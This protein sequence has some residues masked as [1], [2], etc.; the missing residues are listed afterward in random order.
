MVGRSFSENGKVK[1]KPRSFVSRILAGSRRS[2]RNFRAQQADDLVRLARTHLAEDFPNTKREDCPARSTLG[3][4]IES[5]ELPSDDVR[6]HLLICS[7]CFSY[8]REALGRRRSVKRS[9]VVDATSAIRI[10][11]LVPIL[12][13][14]LGTIL[15]A[16]LIFLIVNNRSE[17]EKTNLNS[18]STN[19]TRVPS[20][21][22]ESKA[23][24]A[25]PEQS[26]SLVPPRPEPSASLDRVSSRSLMVQNR[27]SIDFEAYNP[28]RSEGP[29]LRVSPVPLRRTQNQLT[30]QL[31]AGSPQGR[32]RINLTDPYGST[33]QSVE[34]IS[35]DGTQLRLKLN[36]SSVRPG[37]YLIC[38]TRELEVPQC[39]PSMV[40]P[41]N[42]KK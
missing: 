32:Y 34:A 15:L 6:E 10:R 8:Y 36:L 18:A 22:D 25:T 19:N 2:G 12:A 29:P 5:Q 20:E 26:S 38:L 30:V 1:E 35:R 3:A 24:A 40:K 39:I 14:S 13:G 4:I 9:E 21:P 31:P 28:L 16:A 37:N 33:V 11:K 27:V 7:E 42:S 17:G 23:V 41:P